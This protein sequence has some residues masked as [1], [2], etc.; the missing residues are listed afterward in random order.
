MQYC[1][2]C[3]Y[4]HFSNQQSPDADS[5]LSPYKAQYRALAHLWLALHAHRAAL[6]NQVSL[7]ADHVEKACRILRSM[8]G[9]VSADDARVVPKKSLTPQKPPVRT[10][11]RRREPRATAATATTTKKTR[12]VSTTTT[13]AKKVTSTSRKKEPVTPALKRAGTTDVYPPYG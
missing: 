8:F 12:V 3:Q 13:A 7:V 5:K 6:P 4:A 9:K 11:A 1:S 2:G 10:A